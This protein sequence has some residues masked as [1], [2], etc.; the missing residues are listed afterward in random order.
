MKCGPWYWQSRLAALLFIYETVIA[1]VIPNSTHWEA[2]LEKY[3][4]ED[5]EWEVPKQRGRR[6][7]TESDMHLILDLHNKL[8]GQVYPQAANMEYMVWD[9]ELERSAEA[10]SHVCRWE[11]GPAN[12]LS[13]IGQNLGVHWGRERPPT[14]HVQAWY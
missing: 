3:L 11:H 10:W 4:D 5:G 14:F 13:Q 1:M 2:I 8:R 7:I 6:S 12:L 9:A